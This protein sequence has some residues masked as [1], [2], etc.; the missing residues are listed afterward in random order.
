[1]EMTVKRGQALKT[2][3]SAPISTKVAD[4]RVNEDRQLEAERS[5]I[6]AELEA[7]IERSNVAVDNDAKETVL[8]NVVYINQNAKVIQEKWIQMGEFL[9]NIH[10]T[11]KD[12][13]DAI[14]KDDSRILPFTRTVAHKIKQAAEEARKKRVPAEML[15]LT[16]PAAYEV[17]LMDEPV[18]KRALSKDLIKP[19]TSRERLFKI[20]KEIEAEIHSANR[21]V[22]P[23]SIRSQ[24]ARLEQ[25]KDELVDEYKDKLRKID[26]ELERLRAQL[27]D[28]VRERRE[29]ITIEGRVTGENH[30]VIA[31]ERSLAGGNQ[32]GD[33]LNKEAA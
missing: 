33:A 26:E 11:S 9:I 23:R 24:I 32:E 8:R 4:G 3:P 15:P 30:E 6:R 10:K 18:L 13:Y 21:D 16:Y 25:K 1:M 22:T 12:L 2:P 29:A 19:S 7:V 14:T 27:D 20:R 28:L 31:N 5:A 17:S